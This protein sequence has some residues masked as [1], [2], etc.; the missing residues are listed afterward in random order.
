MEVTIYLK[1]KCHFVSMEGADD[2][3]ERIYIMDL[4]RSATCPF[5]GKLSNL[6]V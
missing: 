6:S 5:K 1:K 3:A 4:K 2:V